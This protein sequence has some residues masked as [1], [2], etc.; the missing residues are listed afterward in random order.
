MGNSSGPDLSKY[1]TTNPGRVIMKNDD[2]FYQDVA[3][4]TPSWRVK[5]TLVTIK[6][7]NI[8]Q[9]EFLDWLQIKVI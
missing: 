9:Q 1:Y 4:R 2:T 8:V 6:G 3:F 5:N 7:L